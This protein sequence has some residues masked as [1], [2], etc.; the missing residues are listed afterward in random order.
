[1]L[2]TCR[3]VFDVGESSF[4]STRVKYDFTQI[5]FRLSNPHE[6]G[7]IYHF[8]KFFFCL[9]IF[10]FPFLPDFCTNGRLANGNRLQGEK[11]LDDSRHERNTVF[12]T[13]SRHTYFYT[14]DTKIR[15]NYFSFSSFL[16]FFPRSLNNDFCVCAAYNLKSCKHL[17]KTTL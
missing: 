15:I 4:S 2:I 6:T 14:T 16:H 13:T 8:F 17:T 12:F 7:L 11:I 5:S 10:Y 3:Y 9:T 1:M